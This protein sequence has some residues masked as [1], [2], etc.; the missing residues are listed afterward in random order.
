MAVTPLAYGDGMAT[1]LLATDE[2]HHQAAPT[3]SSHPPPM[4]CSVGTLN[5]AQQDVLDILGA[6][7]DELPQFDPMLRHKLQAELEAGTCTTLADLPD[8]ETLCLSKHQLTAVHGC[9]ARLVAEREVPFE[10]TAPLA[11]GA[12]AH[13][14][15]ELSVFMGASTPPIVLVEE[16]MA[17]LCRNES[18]L[19]DWLRRIAPRE[20]AEL[21]LEANDRVSKFVECFPPLK[22]NWVPVTE[23]RLRVELFEGRILL[24]GRVDLTLGRAQGTTAKKVII[25]LKTGGF[26]PHHIDDLRFYALLEALRVGVPPRLVATYYLDSGRPYAERVTEAVL[27]AAVARVRDGAQRLVGLLHGS[28]TPNKRAGAPCRWC[29]I[30]AG[31][32]EAG[33]FLEDEP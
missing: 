21:Q 7:G 19:A 12:V 6:C 24:L 5:P 3:A 23:S 28:Q 22:S 8:G 4:T 29:P 33:A 20:R 26:A 31:C 17:S 27:R 15:I 10:W 9:E 30:R 32:P 2:H 16:A 14:A 25:D 13:K 1:D 11:R 18:G